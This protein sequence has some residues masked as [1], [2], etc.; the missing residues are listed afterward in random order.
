MR[1]SWGGGLNALDEEGQSAARFTLNPFKV[2]GTITPN[3]VAPLATMRHPN[4]RIRTVPG[5]VVKI[6]HDDAQVFHCVAPS[7]LA[8]WGN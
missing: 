6:R 8:S 2:S 1:L 7:P 5:S 3:E 4:H